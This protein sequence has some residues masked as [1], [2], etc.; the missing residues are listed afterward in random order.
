M[1]FTEA[2][3]LGP[4]TDSSGVWRRLKRKKSEFSLG[5]FELEMCINHP[6]EAG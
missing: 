4:G 2:E 6:S 5:S 1:P 3:D